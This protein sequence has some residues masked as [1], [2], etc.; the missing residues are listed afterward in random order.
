MFQKTERKILPYIL[1]LL[2]VGFVWVG[3]GKKAPPR[4]PGPEEAPAT[5]GR[6]SKTISVDTLS[7]TWDPV[8]K[9]AAEPAGFYVFRSKVRLTDSACPTCPVFF[10][11]VAAIP[12]REKG[13]GD[14]A[15]HPFEYR[16]TLARGFRYIYKVAAYSNSGAIG[17]D[18]NTVEFTH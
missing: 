4:P 2:A 17:K 11:R 13:S 3:C 5:V 9:K 7:L 1:I 10:E 14:A 18:S 15:P 8:T 16:E 6:L 12:Y